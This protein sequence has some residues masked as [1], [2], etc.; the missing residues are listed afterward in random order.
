[1]LTVPVSVHPLARP[2]S[3]ARRAQCTPGD[4]DFGDREDGL[5]GGDHSHAED[6]FNI[7]GGRSEHLEDDML[8]DLGKEVV[9][10]LH[11]CVMFDK[12]LLKCAH[13]L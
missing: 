6:T 2:L 10:H 5:L 3:H 11:I 12:L 1:V 13:I 8:G 7:R 4:I 9:R